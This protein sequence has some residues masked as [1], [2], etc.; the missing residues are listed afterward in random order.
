MYNEWVM[1]YKTMDTMVY[2]TMYYKLLAYKSMYTMVYGT[3]YTYDGIPNHVYYGV[4]NHI[5]LRWYKKPFKPWIIKACSMYTRFPSGKCLGEWPKSENY[6]ARIY[7][8]PAHLLRT[9]TACWELTASTHHVENTHI[10]IFLRTDYIVLLVEIVCDHI[11]LL[12]G[13]ILL[14][15]Q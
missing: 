6:N 14:Y 12:P 1:V 2:E 11:N 15:I 8:I 7:E 10:F 4:R 5:F 3:M 13:T 9:T